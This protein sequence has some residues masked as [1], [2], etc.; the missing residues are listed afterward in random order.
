MPISHARDDADIAEERRL[1]YVGVTRARRHLWLSW[2]TSRPGYA[3]KPMTRRPSRFLYDLG[4]GAPKR[5]RPPPE[6]ARR[7]ADDRLTA[8]LREWRRQ[9]AHRDGQPAFVVFND[10]TLEA[11]AAK[12]PTSTD[13]LLGVHGLGPAKVRR[14]GDDLLRV[15]RNGDEP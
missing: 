2:A 15:L 10:R 8:T 5:T 4:P 12:R 7:P 6:R 11:L 13:E 14:Y 3:G 1:L 9:R